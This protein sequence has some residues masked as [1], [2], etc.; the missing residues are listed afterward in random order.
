[1]NALLAVCLIGFGLA[2]SFAVAFAVWSAI[3]TLRTVTGPVYAAWINQYVE[4]SVR[5]TAISMSSQVNAFGQIVGGPII[6]AIT[7]ALAVSVG[8]GPSLRAAMI[9]A[10][11]I[12]LPVLALCAH[13]IRRGVSS[14]VQAPEAVQEII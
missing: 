5:A 2:C 13:S 4:S 14:P 11:L 12:L 9:L 1:V 3:S 6:G 10:G 8:L 7:T